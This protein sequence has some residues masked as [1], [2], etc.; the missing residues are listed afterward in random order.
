MDNST[1]CKIVL[2][3]SRQ[4]TYLKSEDGFGGVDC[5]CSW[6]TLEHS[7]YVLSKH[8][9]DCSQFGSVDKGWLVRK[10]QVYYWV[11]SQIT[12]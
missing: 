5:L 4:L 7:G 10:E 12:H 3:V 1:F 9:L 8:F 2:E 11:F 6:Y